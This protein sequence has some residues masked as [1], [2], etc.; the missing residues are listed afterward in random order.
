VARLLGPDENTRLAYIST[1]GSTL[2]SAAGKSAIIYADSAASTL[3]DILTEAGG[4][5]SGSTLTID[6]YSRFPL[7]QFPDGVDT[8][9]AVVNGGPTVALYAR[10]D[11]R[12]DALATRMTAIEAGGAGDALLLHKAG[13]ET[14]TGVKTFS[15]SP[16]VPSPLGGTDAANK[17]YADTTAAAAAASALASA[18]HLTGNETIAGTKTFSS[19]PSVPDS[20]FAEAK[21]T[22]LV[23]D[24]AAKNPLAFGAT[25]PGRPAISS[26]I[27]TFQSGHG[28]SVLSS[29]L[30]SAAD[31]TADYVL[32]TQCYA[33]TTKTDNTAG[34]VQKTG[35]TAFDAT[36][37][38][39][40]LVAK[41]TDITNLTELIVYAGDNTFTNI[42]QWTVQDGGLDAQRFFKSGEWAFITL[43]FQD[44]AVT[45][46]PTRN[47]LTAVRLRCR[48]SNTF[49][50][51]VRWQGVGLA[52]EQS[53]YP[54]GVVSLSFDDTYASQ[55]S[56]ARVVMDRY[57]YPGT[58]YT[59]VDA[60]GTGGFMTLAQLHALEDVNGWDV[61]GHAYTLADHGT[62]LNNLSNPALVAD[63]SQMRNWLESNGFRGRQHL[64]YPLGA[65]DPTTIATCRQYFSSSRSIISRTKAE[66]VN[67]ADPF[68]LR[69][70]SLTNSN[71][72]ASVWT[73][74]IDNAYTNKAW[75][76][77]TFHNLV[78]SGPGANDIL[79][80][81]FTTIVDYIATKGM[82]V[83]TVREVLNGL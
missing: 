10:T 40:V 47:S 31:D 18:V 82:P 65:F 77:L 7:F 49:S 72:P 50:T 66:T 83:K 36:G 67:P 35:I 51:T 25:R 43:S 1:A 38:S 28:F 33:A 73:T 71:M 9:Y 56:Q 6:A 23:T 60:V 48:C 69:S 17:T 8:V 21:V 61:A 64:A 81:D 78:T 44:A 75:L 74:A 2:R 14:V 12:L 53:T 16:V 41:V 76:H 45:G 29:T 4:A 58:A 26:W 5:V 52:A 55:Y 79:V 27:T 62:G 34:S 42:Y 37:K 22:N 15:A 54:N 59:I 46:S 24:L 63:L 70:A 20:S 39:L 19:A 13:A 68:K 80:S 57:G 3:A 32:G 11:D 30:A